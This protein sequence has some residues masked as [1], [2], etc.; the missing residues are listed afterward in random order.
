LLLGHIQIKAESLNN[1]GD[2]REQTM[3]I[4][5]P[6]PVTIVYKTVDRLS[7]SLDVYANSGDGQ[8]KPRPAI[9]FFHG[10]GLVGN[11]FSVPINGGLDLHADIHLLR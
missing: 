8:G 7:L 5:I 11:V 10:G 6:E 2:R 1:P 9:V 3:S 4:A